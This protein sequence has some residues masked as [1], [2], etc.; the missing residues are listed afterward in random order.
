MRRCRG[1]RSEVLALNY[2]QHINECPKYIIECGYCGANL[3]KIEYLNGHVT[4]KDSTTERGFDCFEHEI[5]TIGER[6]EDLK[7]D[8]E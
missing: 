7:E 8:I 3:P 6:V 5:E 2:D 1:C 4:R